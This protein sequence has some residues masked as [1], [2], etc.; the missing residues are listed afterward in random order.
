MKQKR[1]E[2]RL[3]KRQ[4]DYDKNNGTDGG[5]TRPGSIKKSAGSIKK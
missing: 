2:V 1:K 3:K 4:D 5:Y